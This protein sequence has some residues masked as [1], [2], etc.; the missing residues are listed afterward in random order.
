M[1]F[2]S[3]LRLF[4]FSLSLLLAGCA[5]AP[6]MHYKDD[7]NLTAPSVAGA[8]PSRVEKIELTPKTVALQPELQPRVPKELLSYEPGEYHLGPHDVVQ[9]VVWDHPE[10]TAP[11]ETDAAANAREIG[12]KGTI[13]V[14]Y[15]GEVK[16]GGLT[17]AQARRLIA[18]RLSAY[19]A[20]PQVDLVIKT[21]NSQHITVGGEVQ[22]PGI[23]PLTSQPLNL[24]DAI[25]LAGGFTPLADRTHVTLI[26]DDK[27][28]VLDLARLMQNQSADISRIFIR[29]GD[30]IQVADN[31]SQKVYVLG[32]VGKAKEV[33]FTTHGLTLTDALGGVG[34]VRQTTGDPSAV[35]VIRAARAAD[36]PA[37]IFHLDAHSP[38]A[39]IIADN[40]HLRP[41]DVI[42]VGT[43]AISR[44]NR[45]ISQLLPS[46]NVITYS[47]YFR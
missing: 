20:N 47:R 7:E 29:D 31:S 39:L 26:R 5:F 38:A 42:F 15:V 14:P 46:V 2:Q 34:G 6:G 40:F 8:P 35:Y 4:S 30:V 22:K 43:A 18:R 12:L 1:V 23:K 45:F 37:R 36:E 32:E 3:G 28:Y 27:K 24:L 19:I 17:V 44:W 41:R 16:I 10:L 11:G 9:M 13:F 25:G 21:Y 33:P